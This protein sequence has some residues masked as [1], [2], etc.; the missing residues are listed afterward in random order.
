MRDG[1]P[2][3]AITLTARELAVGITLGREATVHAPHRT[4]GARRALELSLTEALSRPPCGIAFSGGRDSSALLALAC[5]VARAEG[6]PLPVPL[7]LRFAETEADETA[8]QQ[9]VIEHLRLDDW[10][11]QRCGPEMVLTGPVAARLVGAEGPLH[12]ANAHTHLALCSHVAGGS[13]VTGA[14]GDEVFASPPEALLRRLSR[15]QLPTVREVG[16]FVRSSLPGRARRAGAEFVGERPWI[17]SGARQVLAAEVG[18]SHWQLP[19]R[20]DRALVAW[21]TDRYYLSLRHTLAAVGRVGDVEVVAPFLDRRFLAA[22]AGESGWGGPDSRAH[23]MQRLFG[24]VLP[25]GVAERTSKA[26][27][28]RSLHQTDPLFLREWEGEGVPMDLVDVEALREEWAKPAPHFGTALLL[29]SAY[30]GWKG[31]A[32][33]PRASSTPR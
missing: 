3:P 33:G 18:R 14:G 4:T 27:F 32:P 7:T 11:R 19:R 23:E 2:L 13:L 24:D 8:W 30:F 26:T 10:V 31:L 1:A 21:V 29:Q 12:P 17:R 20:F 5:S 6:L 28:T 25:A 15:R 16:A 9:L 22:F